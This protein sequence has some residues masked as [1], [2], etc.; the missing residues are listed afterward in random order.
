MDINLDIFPNIYIEDGSINIKEL[1]F[2]LYEVFGNEISQD[3]VKKLLQS[4][5]FSYEYNNVLITGN[6]AAIFGIILNY[7]DREN[8][9]VFLGE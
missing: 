6:G 7:L 9:R 2:L 8:I 5:N 3:K 1:P 4:H